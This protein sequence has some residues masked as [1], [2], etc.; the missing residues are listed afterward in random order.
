CATCTAGQY[1][2]SACTATANTV[3]INCATCGTGQYQTAACSATADATCATCST[4]GAEQYETGA[5]GGTSNRVCGACATCGAGQYEN[6]ACTPTT[7]RS[8]ATCAVCGAGQ[9]RTSACGGTSNTTCAPCSVCGAGQ[10]RTAACS[11]T[12]NTVCA[13]CTTCTVGQF[14]MTACGGSNDTVCANCDA[15]CDVCAGAN[16]CT[17]C[18]TGFALL[19]GACVPTG[20]SCLG[21]HTANPAAPDGVYQLDPDGGSSTNAFFAYCDMTADGG[22]WMKILQYTDAPYTPTAAA[23]GNIAVAGISAM[24][25]LADADVNSLANLATNREYRFQG[26]LSTKKLF[27]KVGA[28]WNDTARAHGLMLTAAGL[29]CE[30]TTNCTYVPVFNF[31]QPTID[32]FGWT[33][34]FTGNDEDR[35]FTDFDSPIKCYLPATSTQ[36]CYSAGLSVGVILIPNFSIW[37]R[38]VPVGRDGIILYPLDENAGTAVADASGNGHDATVVAG[39]WTPGHTGSA[40]LG[41][42]RTSAAV[43]VTNAVTVSLWVRRDGAG[44]GE[45][46]VLSWDNDGLELGD[47]GHANVLGVSVPGLGWQSTGT[48]FGAGFHHVAVAVGG[49][50]VRVYFDGM[51]KYAGSATINLAGQMSIGMRWNGNDAWVG[52]VDQVRVYDRMLSSAEIALLSQE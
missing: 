25:K 4:C 12:A 10:Y 39:S 21:I 48:S 46:R 42:L 43:P 20:S 30:A 50:T 19:N 23:V 6:R 16:V 15:H 51:Q 29:A 9:Y 18:A 1:R 32:S 33:P 31:I 52:A 47:V 3:C 35:F 37:T 26:G 40:L 11:A 5:C 49:G 7:N 41:A 14:V 34:P 17:T 2:A 24:A 44:T 27:M 38:E 13:T 8:C 45:T 28:P 22:G 36:R